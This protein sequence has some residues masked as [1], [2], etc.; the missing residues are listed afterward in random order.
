M[1][2]GKLSQTAWNRA[3]MK[4]LY[5]KQE[6]NLLKISVAESCSAYA[7]DDEQVL[8]KSAASTSGDTKKLGKYPAI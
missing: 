8:I 7:V 5:K 4:Q 6:Q 2:V 1:K 3:V